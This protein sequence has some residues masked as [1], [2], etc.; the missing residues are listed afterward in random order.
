MIYLYFYK[1]SIK[2]FSAF[3]LLNNVKNKNYGDKPLY[4]FVVSLLKNEEKILFL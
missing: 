1:I 3:Y 4:S 2:T